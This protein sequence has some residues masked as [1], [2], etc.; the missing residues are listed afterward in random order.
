MGKR[1]ILSVTPNTA[2]DYTFHVP[3]FS[4]GRTIRSLE[5]AWGMGG[6]AA[7]AAWILGH[8][9]VANLAMGFAA[10]INGQRME[11]MLRE[12]GC[13]TDFVWV[14]GETRLNTV[15]CTGGKH[16][17]FTSSTL[18]VTPGKVDT[19]FWRYEKALESASCLI[20]GG[21]TPNGVPENFFSMVIKLACSK[22]IP[23]IFDSSG[24]CLKD[25]LEARPQ[26]I[27]PNLAE[28][29]DL[30]DNEM[31]PII[32]PEIA[33]DEMRQIAYSLAS[34]VQ[35][36]YG[37]SLVVTLGSEGAFAL[38]GN[39]HYWIPSLPVE[40]VSAAGAGDAVLAGLA[41]SYSQNLPIE[42]GLRLGFALA[43]SV[44]RTLATADFKIN[45]MRYYLPLIKLLPIE[46]VLKDAFQ[47]GRP[48]L[49]Q[50]GSA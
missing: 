45:D 18:L 7:D 20:V 40:V 30:L 11:G 12:R 35:A 33:S 23:V 1:M 19:F 5:S 26:I 16:S 8:L 21:T 9:G 39:T 2:I 22:N 14:D 6:K 49:K 10:G 34:Q 13:Q 36:R 3:E 37:V 43:T 46:G 32:N 27:K 48:S 42:D 25:G 38:F 29:A 50:A 47:P 44:L 15:I 41:V 17:T 4:L 24:A 31:T 28:L